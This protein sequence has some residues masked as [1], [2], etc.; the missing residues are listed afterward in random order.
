MIH[1]IISAISSKLNFYVKNKLSI[2]DDV[3]V[4]RNLIDLKGNVSDGIENKISV[5]LLGLEEDKTSK[6]KSL[7]RIVS[8]PVVTL[9]VNIMFAAY[10]TNNSYLESLRY[11][12]LVLEFFQKNPNFDFEDT[13]GL[14]YECSQIH[15][16]IYNLDIES[17][18]RLWSSIG[19][20][21]IPSVAYK[22]KHV[23]ID[24]DL[25]YEDVPP[26]LGNS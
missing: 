18:M 5:F 4:I 10:F 15:A 6:N 25:V 8:P 2:D 13:P 24:S 14:P 17:N 19:A 1:N 11:I 21:Y 22:I 12:T 3:V 7:G 16:Q 9:N 26:I 23:L 20:K